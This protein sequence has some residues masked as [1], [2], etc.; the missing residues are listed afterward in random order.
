MRLPATPLAPI[1]LALGVTVAGHLAM[2]VLNVTR[3]DAGRYFAPNPVPPMDAVGADLQESLRAAQGFLQGAK[4][5]D[6]VRSYAREHDRWRRIFPYPPI[7]VWLNVPLARLSDL[8]ALRVW[9][10]L[11]L[12]LF[13]AALLLYAGVAFRALETRWAALFGVLLVFALSASTLLELER[14][15]FDWVVA[16]LWL[17]AAAALSQG[18]DVRAGIALGLAIALKVY[19]LALLPVLVVS[20]RF[21]ALAATGATIVLVVLAFGVRDH[22][23][24]LNAL[25]AERTGLLEVRAWSTTLANALGWVLPTVNPG[26]ANVFGLAVWAL[27]VAALSAALHRSRRAGSPI[28]PAHAMALASPLQFMVPATSWSYTLFTVLPVLL[29]AAQLWRERPERRPALAA[30]GAGLGMCQVPLVAWTLRDGPSLLVPIYSVSL[31]VVAVA[32]IRAAWPAAQPRSS[33]PT[34]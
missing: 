24:W 2:Q 17:V 26:V 10:A 7:V 25:G 30:L 9:T 14:G 21:K 12:L 15:N 4:D 18:S 3:P 34:T 16:A 11:F 28:E 19:P 8:D 22:W 27:L 32:G 13:P 33:S 23:Q 1:A 29:V 31:F 20:R 6:G 5:Y